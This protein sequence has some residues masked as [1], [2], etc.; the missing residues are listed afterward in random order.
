MNTLQK[1]R[2]WLNEHNIGYEYKKDDDFEEIKV[3]RVLNDYYWIKIYQRGDNRRTSITNE[4][5][6]IECYKPNGEA[7][8]GSIS[9]RISYKKLLNEL[10]QKIEVE[11]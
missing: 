4:T 2:K 3:W 10:K 5:F 7:Y 6:D 11:N 9:R 1:V 8:Q